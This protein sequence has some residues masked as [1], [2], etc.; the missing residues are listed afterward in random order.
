M[1]TYFVIGEM[2]KI[3]NISTQT[4]RLYDRIGLLKPASIDENNGYRYYSIDQFIKL[5]CIKRCK[6]M[7][8]SLDEIKELMGND[9]SIEAMLELTKK[10]K[11]TIRNKIEELQLMENQLNI[12]EEKIKSSLDVGFNK[13]S[14]VENEERMFMKF[15]DNLRTQEELEL[16]VRELILYIEK[17]HKFMDNDISFFISYDE[18]L[19]NKVFFKSI[20]MPIYNEDEFVGENIIKIPKGKYVTMYIDESSIDNRKYYKEML[21]FIEENNMKVAGDFI[22]NYLVVRV[23][24]DGKENTLAKLEILCE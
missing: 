6:A 24:K 22:E 7:G 4:L 9:S 16:S 14:I 5:E 17:K 10:Q 23:N 11:N 18:I 2:A 8:F 21:N 13:I 20:L 15:K 12:L 19:N 3:F 1:S